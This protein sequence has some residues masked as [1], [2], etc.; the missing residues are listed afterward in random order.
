MTDELDATIPLRDPD[1]LA[2]QLALLVEGVYASVQALGPGGHASQARRTAE[3]LIA[4][5]A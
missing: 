1:A 2:D 4:A 5:S 3:T